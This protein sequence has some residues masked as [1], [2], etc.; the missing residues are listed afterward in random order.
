MKF[1][2]VL[3]ST[4]VVFVFTFVFVI[5]FCICSR[6]FPALCVV[7]YLP[8]LQLYFS[9]R[10]KKLHIISI[11]WPKFGNI[12][13]KPYLITYE[14]ESIFVTFLSY[15]FQYTRT[16]S[17]SNMRPRFVFTDYQLLWN[18]K[19]VWLWTVVY[20]IYLPINISL[21]FLDGSDNQTCSLILPRCLL[22]FWRLSPPFSIFLLLPLPTRPSRTICEF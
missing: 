3:R 18:S 15:S 2:C 14:S 16:S 19:V 22:E 12:L 13:S 7:S 9:F 10:W 5:V 11:L 8:L 6:L 1:L 21:L 20:W 4:F 17:W